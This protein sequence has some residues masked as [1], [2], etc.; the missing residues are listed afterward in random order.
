MAFESLFHEVRVLRD[1]SGFSHEKLNDVL[2]ISQSKLSAGF[3][4][5]AN[6]DSVQFLGDSFPAADETPDRRGP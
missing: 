4:Q 1:G 5:D 2:V 3:L 6:R